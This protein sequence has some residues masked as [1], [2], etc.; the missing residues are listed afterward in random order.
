MLKLS[1]PRTHSL[2]ASKVSPAQLKKTLNPGNL[3]IRPLS[4]PG[5]KPNSPPKKRTL[6]LRGHNG[7]QHRWGAQMLLLETYLS[8]RHSLRHFYIDIHTIDVYESD[9]M[10]RQC[11]DGSHRPQMVVVPNAFTSAFECELKLC[12][13][14]SPHLVV[15]QTADAYT[16]LYTKLFKDKTRLFSYFY[17]TNLLVIKFFLA[18]RKDDEI[19]FLESPQ[20]DLIG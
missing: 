20:M 8:Q 3:K 11:P 17:I 19:S 16:Y 10:G 18:T 13:P 7:I 6:E 4:L 1:P 2:F 15:S 5:F 12:D 14:A 9:S